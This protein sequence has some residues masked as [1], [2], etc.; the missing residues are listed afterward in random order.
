MHYLYI[1]ELYKL[2]SIFLLLIVIGLAS[3]ISTQ[4]AP[5]TRN[6]AVAE[7]PRDAS[8]HWIFG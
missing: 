8:C 2:G 5:E 7:R 6:S 3:F 4:P 1:A